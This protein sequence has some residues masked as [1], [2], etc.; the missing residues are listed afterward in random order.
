MEK[1]FGKFGPITK[2]RVVLDSK[3]GRSRGYAF[4]T[5]VKVEDAT[6]ARSAMAYSGKKILF[7]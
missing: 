2:I 5:F 7:L 6:K 4:V 3:T 1:D